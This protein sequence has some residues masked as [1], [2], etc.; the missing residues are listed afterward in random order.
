MGKRLLNHRNAEEVYQSVLSFIY[1]YGENGE[2]E[3]D[4]SNPLSLREEITDWTGRG[5]YIDLFFS[6]KELKKY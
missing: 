6:E 4:R 2:D 3:Y 1:N 5:Q